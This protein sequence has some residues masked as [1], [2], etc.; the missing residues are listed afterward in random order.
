MHWKTVGAN[1][2]CRAHNQLLSPLDNAADL[3]IEYA[4]GSVRY[5]TGV[6]ALTPRQ[7][8]LCSGHDI[9]RWFLK[10]FLGGVFSKEVIRA[11]QFDEKKYYDLTRDF[12]DIIPLKANRGL[13]ISPKIGDSIRV[14]SNRFKYEYLVDPE[15]NPIGLKFFGFAVNFHFIA[16]DGFDTS[17][18]TKIVRSVRWSGSDW[19]S[20]INIC[21]M[22]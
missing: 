6:S 10:L 12:Y 14:D 4:I 5:R 18:L 3:M 7:N 1:I 8:F 21:W 17:K 15:G 13:F 19:K 2:L 20:T 16:F 9:E 11:P 22:N